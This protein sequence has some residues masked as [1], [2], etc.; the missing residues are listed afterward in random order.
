MAWSAFGWLGVA[1]AVFV[2]IPLLLFSYFVRAR[3]KAGNTDTQQ[4]MSIWSSPIPYFSVFF[5]VL[6]GAHIIL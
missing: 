3:L 4:P 2:P 6:I 5:V 1:Y